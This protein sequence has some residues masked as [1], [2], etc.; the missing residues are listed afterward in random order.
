M[1]RRSKEAYLW[2]IADSCRVILKF[3]H[4]RSFADYEK[5]GCSGGR[6]N[7]SFR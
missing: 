6:S 2:D 3:V 7:G 1:Q 5:T 4:G